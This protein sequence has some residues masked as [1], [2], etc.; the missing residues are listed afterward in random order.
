MIFEIYCDESGLEAINDK[1]AHKYCAIG[2]IWIPEQYRPILKEKINSIKH[3]YN[4]YGELKWNKVSPFTIQCYKDV[5]DY[6]FSTPRIRFRAIIIE[7]SKIDNNVFNNGDAELGFYKFYYQLINHWIT[8]NNEY[9]IFLDHKINANKDRVNELGK[10]LQN[11]N[12]NANVKYAQAIHSHESVAIQLA[13]I[14]TG[15]VFAKFNKKTTSPA[16][17]ELIELVEKHLCK[18]IQETRRLEEK[19]NVFNINLRKG[20]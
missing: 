20:W 11:S 15:I 8:E 17:L 4:I 1:S 7:S 2:G 18:E 9:R 5:I 13:D 10:I 12:I 6:F 3:E 14:L 16:K 19:F